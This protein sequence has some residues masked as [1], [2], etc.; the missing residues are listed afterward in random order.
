MIL[1]PKASFTVLFL[2]VFIHISSF[3][4]SKHCSCGLEPSVEVSYSGPP[5]DSVG[6]GANVIAITR[7]T[8]Q[9]T[10]RI[11]ASIP[12]RRGQP[13]SVR[14]HTIDNG[15]S[16]VKDGAS[17]SKVLEFN[18]PPVRYRLP[19]SG[20]R[21]ERSS[22]NG[23]HWKQALLLVNNASTSEI[24]GREATSNRFS[25]RFELAAIHPLSPDTVYGCFTAVTPVK[26]PATLSQQPAARA[27]IYVSTDGGDH[28][29]LFFQDFRRRS[30]EEPCLIGISAIDPN[31]MVLHGQSWLIITRD[32]G[33]DWVPAGDQAELESPAH[34]KGY[35]EAS[36]RLKSKHISAAKQRPYDWTYLTVMGIVFDPRN[37]DTIYLV[38][39]KGLYITRDAG[40][41]WCLLLTGNN[42]LFA[43]G[44]V[45]IDESK[46]NRVFVS[47]GTTV[48]VS[49]DGGCN[50]ELFLDAAKLHVRE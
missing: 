33:K 4:A 3:A 10:I 2:A 19:L 29:S 20:E 21:L 11:E 24:A 44:S 46:S 30:F 48:L 5:S 22:D 41:N 25:W 34:L 17:I 12:D 6:P 18:R 28:W 36:E 39:N 13:Q 16:W 42:T 35:V 49:R 27:G 47:S 14:F 37:K 38:T 23:K 15:R 32:G 43:V 26:R 8:N 1:P 45:F 40:K 50:F 7:G 31:V 9:E